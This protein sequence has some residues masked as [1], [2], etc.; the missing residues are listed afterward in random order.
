[1]PPDPRYYYSAADNP[2]TYFGSPRFEYITGVPYNSRNARDSSFSRRDNESLQP[3]SRSRPRS[4]DRSTRVHSSRQRNATSRER[5]KYRTK[6]ALSRRR[7]PFR[8]N[9]NSRAD[10]S[11]KVERCSDSECNSRL[12]RRMNNHKHKHRHSKMVLEKK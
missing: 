11:V 1:M 5:V 3:R 4:L 10:S 6:Y 9:V 12:S 7:Q 8:S 2:V